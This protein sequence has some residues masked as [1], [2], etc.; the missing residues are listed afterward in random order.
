MRGA[1][2]S[3]CPIDHTSYTCQLILYQF[4]FALWVQNSCKKNLCNSTCDSMGNHGSSWDFRCLKQT[5][6]ETVAKQPQET[7]QNNETVQGMQALSAPSPA[8]KVWAKQ[9]FK[10]HFRMAYWLW[11]HH[12][13]QTHHLRSA[14]RAQ[15]AK[16]Q[17]SQLTHTTIKPS[18]L[19]RC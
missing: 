12:S 16:G 4:S 13:Q 15:G 18:Y 8:L 2:P 11:V 6:R 17:E 19:H 1:G 7:A 5:Q 10:E 9:N 14:K 3:P